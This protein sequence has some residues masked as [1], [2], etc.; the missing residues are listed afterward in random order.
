M[1]YIELNYNCLWQHDLSENTLHQNAIENLRIW[2]R[3]KIYVQ[4]D[5][6]LDLHKNSNLSL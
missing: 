1:S 6:E 2:I 3:C 4:N 5:I